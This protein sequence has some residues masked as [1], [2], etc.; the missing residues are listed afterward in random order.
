[1][2]TRRLSTALV[3][4]AT[5]GFALAG[6]SQAKRDEPPPDCAQMDKYELQP[7]PG[8]FSGRWYSVPD[9]TNQ[10]GVETSLVTVTPLFT[11][12][13]PPLCELNEGILFKS[14]GNHD[15]GSFIG[16][17]HDPSSTDVPLPLVGGD[18]TGF[19]GLSFWA[20]SL[21]DKGLTLELT[22][23]TSDDEA[24]ECQPSTFYL[25]DAGMRVCTDAGMQV[26]NPEFNDKY[27]VPVPNACG[28]SFDAMVLLT[29]RWA[30]YTIPF[31]SFRQ[32]RQDPSLKPNGIDVAHIWRLLIRAPRGAVVE[33]SF[34][35]LAW[36]RKATH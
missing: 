22:D 14:T 20:K 23:I 33:A 29:E 11:A 15:W 32:T 7:V 24:G 3:L 17:Y 36:Y 34:A 26:G 5:F 10:Q 21:Y 18:A 19:E 12:T 25:N 30:F 9:R 4:C 2:S 31:K 27:G 8:F 35:N 16:V 13:T 28:N 6:C 1:M